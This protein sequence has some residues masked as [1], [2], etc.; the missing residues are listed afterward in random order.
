LTLGDRITVMRAGELQQVG[1]P[2]QLYSRPV[3][4][5]VAGFIGS[6]SMNFLPGELDGNT[7]RLPLGTL[8]LPDLL[9][10]K[11][12]AGPGGGRRGVI[13]GLR[14]EH[15]EDAALVG[16]RQHG[17]VTYT[18]N[19]DVLESLGSEY[20]AY[21]EV[22]SERVSARELEELAQDA[23]S[24]DLPLSHDQRVPIVARLSGESKARQGQP[25]ELWFDPQH[26]Q[27]FD[28]ETGRSLLA[29]GQ[30]QPAGAVAQL[31]AQAA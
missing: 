17:G 23:G 13:A 3:N 21:F 6:P 19:L 11:L 14:P 5:F 9:R 28:P 15:F 18:A 27:R 10:R 4:L 2:S 25:L 8:P 12:E 31:P 7:V 16:A 20:Y 29:G 24:A 30:E 26:L 1:S 22:E